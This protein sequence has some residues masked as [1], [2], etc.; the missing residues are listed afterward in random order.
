MPLGYSCTPFD[1]PYVCDWNGA[2]ITGDDGSGTISGTYYI[3]TTI[4]ATKSGVTLSGTLR[5]GDGR[6]NINGSFPPLHYIDYT[7]TATRVP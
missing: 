2:S 4:A 6:G 5:I 3:N 7:F 1:P